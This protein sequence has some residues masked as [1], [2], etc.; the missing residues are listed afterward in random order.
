VYADSCLVLYLGFHDAAIG[1]AESAKV[2][3]VLHIWQ[4]AGFCQVLFSIPD[5]IPE[6]TPDFFCSFSFIRG[7]RP[8]L[9]HLISSERLPY[10]IAYF[11]SMA[12]TLYATLV[13]R[14]YFLIILLSIVQ[15]IAIIW[16]YVSYLP[17]GIAGLSFLT[18]SVTRRI[19]GSLLPI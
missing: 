14:S 16:F 5:L 7:L 15:M 2:C 17:G 19:G 18:R 8:F 6:F 9:S 1:F 4:F 12:C 11:G 10:S 3:A 13:V